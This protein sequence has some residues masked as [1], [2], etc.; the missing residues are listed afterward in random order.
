[1]K[2]L[3]SS[4][5]QHQNQGPTASKWETKVIVWLTA[6]LYWNQ[7]S[8]LPRKPASVCVWRGRHQSCWAAVRCGPQRRPSDVTLQ[9]LFPYTPSILHQSTPHN[10]HLPILTQLFFSNRNLQSISLLL[11]IFTSNGAEVSVHCS[12][13]ILCESYQF[14]QGAPTVGRIFRQHLEVYFALFLNSWFKFVSFYFICI[15]LSSDFR[16]FRRGCIKSSSE[17]SVTSPS[18]SSCSNSGRGAKGLSE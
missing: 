15:G 5:N 6:H 11:F 1:M 18:S 14:L 2:L 3:W 8:A 12:N 9:Y 17:S 4:L 16:R 10:Q 7:T 13:L